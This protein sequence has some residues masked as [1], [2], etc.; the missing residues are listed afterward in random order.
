MRNLKIKIGQELMDIETY[1]QNNAMLLMLLE[2][3]LINDLNHDMSLKLNG[4]VDITR[5]MMEQPVPS[6]IKGFEYN[7]KYVNSSFKYVLRCIAASVRNERGVMEFL[8]NPKWL[9]R[10]LQ[11][12]EEWKEEEQIANASKALRLIVRNDTTYDKLASLYPNLG[13]FLLLLLT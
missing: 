5:L 9:N 12:L 3:L 4:M 13:N 10:L 7:K 1:D 6:E 2:P 11:I 8:A